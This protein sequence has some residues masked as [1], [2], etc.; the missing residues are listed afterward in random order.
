MMDKFAEILTVAKQPAL[1]QHIIQKCSLSNESFNNRIHQ[2][3]QS[4]LLDAYP[5]LDLHTPGPKTRRRMIY[6]TSQKGKEFLKRYNELLTLLETS[7][8]YY[9][10]VK[11]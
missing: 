3:L 7:V 8:K 6:Q 9:P 5:A 11:L 4:G 1:K 2:L 10:Q